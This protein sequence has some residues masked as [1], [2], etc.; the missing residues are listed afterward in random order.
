MNEVLKKFQYVELVD[1]SIAFIKITDN[2]QNH[3]KNYI[4]RQSLWH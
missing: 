2:Q 4:P 3:S 1:G